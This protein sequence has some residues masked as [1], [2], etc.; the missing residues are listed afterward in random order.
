MDECLVVPTAVHVLHIA[1]PAV[2]ADERHKAGT[3][4][5]PVQ[6]EKPSQHPANLPSPARLAT[7]QSATQ[8]WPRFHVPLSMPTGSR[9]VT[10]IRTRFH[11]DNLPQRRLIS[12]RILSLLNARR[13]SSSTRSLCHDSW[14]GRNNSRCHARASRRERMVTPHST[15]LVRLPSATCTPSDVRPTSAR[16]R[17]QMGQIS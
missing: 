14:C 10:N 11:Q 7:P 5:P 9:P 16:F 6:A 1:K 8:E 13:C 2:K 15:Q 17:P 12:M 3:M 4:T